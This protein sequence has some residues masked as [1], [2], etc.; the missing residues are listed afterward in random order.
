[1]SLIVWFPSQGGTCSCQFFFIMDYC[2]QTM[3]WCGPRVKGIIILTAFNWDYTNSDLKITI[4]TIVIFRVLAV[5]LHFNDDHHLPP[6][7]ASIT[8]SPPR[9]HQ[10]V[11]SQQVTHHLTQSEDTV[12]ILF[13]FVFF[14]SLIHSLLIM[15]IFLYSRKIMFWFQEHYSYIHFKRRYSKS[16]L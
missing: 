7:S 6:H 4:T 8:K 11:I 16:S 2:D 10:K 13:F 9:G 3:R 12:N 14:N 15:S 5:I 1:M